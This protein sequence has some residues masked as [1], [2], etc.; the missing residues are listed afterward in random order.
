[1]IR[2]AIA[3]LGRF[4]A[5]LASLSLMLAASL[6]VALRRPEVVCPECGGRGG[7]H[8]ASVRHGGWR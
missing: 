5:G 8:V 2:R 3:D 7:R 6:S 4:L 1:M